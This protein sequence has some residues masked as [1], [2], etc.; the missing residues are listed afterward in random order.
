M[1]LM[2]QLYAFAAAAGAESGD[3]ELD[4]A[5]PADAGAVV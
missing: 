5:Q 4:A 3:A 2:Y 1:E